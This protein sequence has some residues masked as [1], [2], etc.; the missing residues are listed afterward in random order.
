MYS[1]VLNV[2]NPGCISEDRDFVRSIENTVSI[3]Q[4]AFT[5]EYMIVTSQEDHVFFYADI[6]N[7]VI[8]TLI[9]FNTRWIQ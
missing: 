3:N 5:Y 4:S 7:I 6:L 2:F 8:K 1:Y 9:M